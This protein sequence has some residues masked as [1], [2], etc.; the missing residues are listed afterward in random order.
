MHVHLKVFLKNNK[1]FNRCSLTRS[2]SSIISSDMKT[3]PVLRSTSQNSSN[4]QRVTIK[5]NSQQA[6]CLF[7]LVG[8][9]NRS[10]SSLWWMV[11]F[12]L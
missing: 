9:H 12:T 7:G 4:V 10:L 11:V 3:D 6:S 1:K 8:P 2:R 5:P